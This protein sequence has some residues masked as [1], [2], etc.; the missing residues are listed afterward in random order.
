MFFRDLNLSVFNMITGIIESKT[1]KN[2]YH[3]SVHVNLMVENLIQ[4]KCGIMINVDASAEKIYMKK[5][6]YI[7]NPATCS[8]KNVK[9]FASIIDSSVIGVIKLQ[10]RKKKKLFLNIYLVKQNVF[11]FDLPFY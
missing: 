3:K 7:Q 10:T 6:I 8:C 2:I 1:L 5:N 4:I 9:Y 11:V